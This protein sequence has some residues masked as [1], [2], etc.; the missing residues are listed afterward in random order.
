MPRFNLKGTGQVPA[1]AEQFDVPAYGLRITDA[2]VELFKIRGMERTA[3][4]LGCRIPERRLNLVI[5][6]KFSNKYSEKL[7]AAL[8]A[9][10]PQD[11][12]RLRNHQAATE[13]LK[14]F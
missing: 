12:I 9:S 14:N 2:V 7:I 3:Q 10:P 1:H 4:K 13:R 11:A 8:E 5:K 6:E